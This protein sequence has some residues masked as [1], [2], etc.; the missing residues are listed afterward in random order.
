MRRSKATTSSSVKALSSESIGTWCTTS[1]KAPL[2]VARDALSRRVRRDELGICGLER[3]QLAHQAVVLGVRNLRIIEHV[4]AV[5][6]LRRSAPQFGG[7]RRRRRASRGGP[8]VQGSR[9]LAIREG[10]SG[11]PCSSCSTPCRRSLRLRAVPRSSSKA[12]GGDFG[13]GSTANR[14]R[15]PKLLRVHGLR[16]R[17]CRAV[18]AR[19]AQHRAVR[20][21]GLVEDG[22]A[23]RARSLPR[24]APGAA[25]APEALRRRCDQT[26][27]DDAALVIRR[28]L[29][30]RRHRGRQ[31]GQDARHGGSIRDGRS[32]RRL[33]PPRPPGVSQVSAA[34]ACVGRRLGSAA[35]ARRDFAARR[36][37]AQPPRLARHPRMIGLLGD[38]SDDCGSA[39]ALESP[40]RAR[41]SAA[42]ARA[43]PAGARHAVRAR[44]SPAA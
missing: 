18:Q 31:L 29:D 14:I 38:P 24:P 21:V 23:S 28:P 34:P 10:V 25:S 8:A 16:D 26:Q 3:A 27:R 20:I 33:R 11:P 12:F 19:G 9:R 2:G 5:V 35:S 39:R 17:R 22:E 36:I 43:V 1:P 13:P 41:A 44:A 15:P 40:G 6:V 32:T 30:H 37:P 42:P 7:T 4:I